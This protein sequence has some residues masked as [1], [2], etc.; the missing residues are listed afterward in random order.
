MFYPRDD[1]DGNPSP[2]VGEVLLLL[3]AHRHSSSDRIDQA[4]L[5]IICVSLL[6]Q[7]GLCLSVSSYYYQKFLMLGLQ[8]TTFLSKSHISSYFIVSSLDTIFISFMMMKSS[9]QYYLNYLSMIQ[10]NYQSNKANL[11]T[12]VITRAKIFLGCVV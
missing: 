6:L 8:N 9:I 2:A 7:S 3:F 10:S 11:K 4:S 5:L 12:L 1:W